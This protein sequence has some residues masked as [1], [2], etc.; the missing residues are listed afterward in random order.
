M[1]GK[2]PSVLIVDDAQV[3]CNILHEELSKRGYLCSTAFNGNDAL[4]KLVAQHFDVVL[5]DI[6]LPDMSGIDVLAR[7]RSNHPNTETIMVTVVSD[8]D[9]AVEA[10]KLGALDYIVKPFNLDRLDATICTISEIK[11]HLTE[12]SDYQTPLYLNS[13]EENKQAMEQSFS[14]MNAIAHGVEAKYELLTGY[15]Y[16]V[17]QRTIEIAQQL[18]IPEEEIQRWADG[19]EMLNSERNRLITSSLNKLGRSPLA[20]SI[21]GMAVPY[22]YRPKPDE[23]QN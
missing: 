20:Q 14:K 10:M 17:T 13:E 12:R 21:M 22:L 8:T 6:R 15:S 19:R 5:L 3:I 11:K 18:G 7:I 9:T 23:L 16:I 1:V 2:K 4:A